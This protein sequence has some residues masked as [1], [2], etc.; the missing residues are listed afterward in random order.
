MKFLIRFILIAFLVSS[1]IPNF[2]EAQ[3]YDSVCRTIERGHAAVG[4][5]EPSQKNI[6]D[7]ID[8]YERQDMW[9][10]VGRW[11]VGLFILAVIVGIVIIVLKN[12]SQGA[13][14]PQDSNNT[15]YSYTAPVVRRGWTVDEKEQVRIRQ[16]G[17]CA[18]CG[19]PP[20]RWDYHHV[21][22]DRS[23]NSMSNCEGLCPNCH[24]VETHEG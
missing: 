7:C 19:K 5:Y 13:Y 21:D 6:Q 20:P 12:A 2:V 16:D 11:G 4:N 22:G 23:N 9:R 3:S 18:H 8:G 15:D 17:K 10:S 14:S 24:S 1:G